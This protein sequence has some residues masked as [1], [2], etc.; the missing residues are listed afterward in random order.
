VATDVIGM[1]LNLPIKTLYFC[2]HEKY[3]GTG[4]RPLFPWE[5]RQIAGR[6][7]RYGLCE[8]GSVGGVS[9]ATHRHVAEALA[10]PPDPAQFAHA[11]AGPTVEH[12][13]AIA[14]L[15]G[16]SSIAA[17]LRFFIEHVHFSSESLRMGQ[18]KDILLNAT[19]VDAC[20]SQLPVGAKWTLA[21]A[22]VPTGSKC[23]GER[24]TF[25]AIL[26]AINTGRSIGVEGACNLVPRLATLELGMLEI[27]VVQLTLYIWVAFRFG[28]H[29]P[30]RERAEELRDQANV[31]I[32]ALL[33]EKEALPVFV[34]SVPPR[35]TSFSG[36]C[37]WYDDDE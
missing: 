15:V 3:D 21:C 23:V 14:N 19:V 6:A 11:V 17:I 12:V 10:A 9:A 33:T 32:A 5:V 36:G 26:A 28:G 31:R 24:D 4:S 1:G 27:L 34:N 18:L 37:R 16:T 2:E 20:A 29:L 13:E 22:P 7:G 25:R 35:Y 8:A 30:E